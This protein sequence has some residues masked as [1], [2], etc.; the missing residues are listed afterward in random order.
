[1]RGPDSA[2][3]TPG[4]MESIA[5]PVNGI[6]CSIFPAPSMTAKCQC[7]ATQGA[8]AARGGYSP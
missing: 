3:A 1:M 8:N 2:A 6:Q 7:A 5:P 4:A